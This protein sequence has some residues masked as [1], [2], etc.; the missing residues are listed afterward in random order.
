MQKSSPED[1]KRYSEGHC[2]GNNKLCQREELE[3]VE[4]AKQGIKPQNQRKS[5]NHKRDAEKLFLGQSIGFVHRHR[6]L[7]NP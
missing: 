6:K 3:S 2:E 7:V 5:K 1:A 4:F